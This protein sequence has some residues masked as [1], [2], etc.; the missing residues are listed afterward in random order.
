LKWNNQGISA[1]WGK[2]GTFL[3]AADLR[4]VHMLNQ[5][6]NLSTI[7]VLQEVI[8]FTETR[9]EVLAGNIANVHTPGY[10]ARDLSVESFQTALKKS[11]AA[12]ELPKIHSPGFAGRSPRQQAAQELHNSKS[13]LLYHDGTN[14]D[15]ERQVVEITKNQSLHNLAIAIMN[16]QFQLLEAAVSERV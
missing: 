8:G 9:H 6:L 11:I 12:H 3:L 7:P 1:R 14:L 16:N 5:I 2:Q 4:E 10:K 15:T 13:T